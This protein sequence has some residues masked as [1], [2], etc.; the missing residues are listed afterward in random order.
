MNKKWYKISAEDK[1]L[2]RMA[3]RIA[4]VLMGKDEPDYEPSGDTGSFV[5]VTEADKVKVSGKKYE[6]KEYFFPSQYPGNSKAKSFK[7]MFEKN[8]EFVIRHAVKGMLPKNKVADKM[9][10]RLKVYTGPEHPH[11]AQEPEELKS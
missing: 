3:S 10:K 11:S 4:V 8:P 1:V 9:L 7:T 2:G 5:I 6:D